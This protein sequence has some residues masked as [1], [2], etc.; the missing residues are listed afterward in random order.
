M[1]STG[2]AYLTGFTRSNNFPVTSGAYDTS[3]NGGYDVIISRLSAD[4]SSLTYSTYFGG[5]SSDEPKSMTL[6]SSGAVY[7]TGYTLSTDF[8]T[9]TGAYDTSHNGYSDGFISR[10]CPIAQ[11]GAITG[12][13]T[14]C[15]AASAVTYSI[16]P[17]LDAVDYT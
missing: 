7:V 17:V 16:A 4:G 1:N 3:Y 12:S 6:D 15:P 9:T 8:P 11:P 5:S 2:S 14:V 13:A 10:L